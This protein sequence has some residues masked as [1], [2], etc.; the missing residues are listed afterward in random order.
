[1]YK[2]S[3][4][5]WCL[6]G[7]EIIKE[8]NL[9][10]RERWDETSPIRD[11]TAA[12][13]L[14]LI[15]VDFRASWRH[16]SSSFQ[17]SQLV[18]IC[19]SHFQRWIIIDSRENHSW[20]ELSSNHRIHKDLKAAFI[21]GTMKFQN[22]NII[23]KHAHFLSH[24]YQRFSQLYVGDRMKYQFRRNSL[25]TRAARLFSLVKNQKWKIFLSTNGLEA[26]KVG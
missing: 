7:S 16:H 22:K 25:K 10:E 12:R 9:E 3:S 1:M 15:G 4:L 5:L 21:H 23:H 19:Q 26:W 17:S 13:L 11:H 14:Q 8:K 24:H 2:Y 18:N 20:K 6:S